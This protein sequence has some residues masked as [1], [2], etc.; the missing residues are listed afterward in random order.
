LLRAGANNTN[1]LMDATLYR[2][3][4]VGVNDR[5]AGAVLYVHA[6]GNY[7]DPSIT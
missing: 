7:V 1:P 6:T 3:V 4:G 2:E 5:T